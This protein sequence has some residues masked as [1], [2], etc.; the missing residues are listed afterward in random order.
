M[1]C[2]DSELDLCF[3]RDATSSLHFTF[4]TFDVTGVQ[5]FHP[6][7]PLQLWATCRFRPGGTSLNRLIFNL[8]LSHSKVTGNVRVARETQ[9]FLPSLVSHV[10]TVTGL[11]VI[12]GDQQKRR[13]G[14]DDTGEGGGEGT[15]GK[16]GAPPFADCLLL[17]LNLIITSRSGSGSK[18]IYLQS[19]IS[20][21][22]QPGNHP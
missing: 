20:S 22:L 21:H 13:W 19:V 7:W 1:T 4:L 16:R 11:C 2:V 3:Y 12:R 8:A 15:E 14:G 6:D 10:P 5:S 9:H 18:W 17:I